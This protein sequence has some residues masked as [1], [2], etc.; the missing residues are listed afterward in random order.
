M[1]ELTPEER[2][3]LAE[4]AYYEPPEPIRHERR[5]PFLR[6]L[7]APF[8][9]LGALLLKF[10][11]LLL[12]GKF[13]L[14]MFVSAAFYVWYGG[15][16]FG[17]GLVL[18]LFVHEMGHVLEA[19]RQGLPVSAPLFIPFL[20]AMITM[21][22]MPQDA[23]NEAKVAI[24][25]PLVGSAG[26]AAIW[27]AGEVTDSN[28]LRGLAFLGFLIN[29]FNLLPVVPLDGGRIVGALHPA[30]WLVGFMGLLGLVF[31]RPN[32]ILIIILLFS[33][34]ELW[35]RW[36]LRNHPEMQSYYRVTPGRRVTMAV[37][38]FGLAVLLVFG[39][40]ATHVDPDL[41]R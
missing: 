1:T 25:G 20:G 15:W 12:K 38:Y 40:N 21:K 5:F 27:I 22:Q 7:F 30:L 36:R 31:L 35:Q 8:L 23:W 14:S 39:M 37:L 16:W 13:L 9:A 34:M 2:A 33:G 32:P 11:G 18:L 26:A 17:I 10:G 4:V 28:H 19:R 3:R 41:L 6:K 29:L 24:A